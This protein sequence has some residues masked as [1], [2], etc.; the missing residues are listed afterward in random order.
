MYSRNSVRYL[1]GSIQ[2]R[3]RTLKFGS[4]DS[5]KLREPI[6]PTHKNFDVNPNHP[7][8]QFFPEG[9]ET[10][11]CFRPRAEIEHIK[12]R[13]WTMAELRRK[14]FEDLHTLWYTVLKERNALGREIRLAQAIQDPDFAQH[15]EIDDKLVKVQKRI[16]VV[17]LERQTAFERTQ[18]MQDVQEKYL[19][20]FKQRYVDATGEGEET[21][22]ELGEKLV[23]LQY[24][25]FG[26]HPQVADFDLEKDVNERMI[27]GIAYIADLK[28]SRY[29]ATSGDKIEGPLDGIVEQL[30]FFLKE[31]DVAVEE[32]REI[33]ENG[34]RKLDKIEV[35]AFVRNALET[36]IEEEAEVEQ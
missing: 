28:F 30:P 16:K 24:A 20:E 25:I 31:T 34:V 19:A 33:R 9:S 22:V 10:E 18:L 3:A 1:S 15:I 36:F 29:L 11:T 17:L 32:L 23:R 21:D 13:P 7:L 35:F 5:I 26:I 6:V 8:W 12:S 4:L 2:A 14:S 27:Q